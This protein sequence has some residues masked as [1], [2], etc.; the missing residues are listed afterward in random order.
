MEPN[1]LSF[2]CP[3]LDSFVA[4]SIFTMQHELTVHSTYCCKISPLGF[5]FVKKKTSFNKKKGQLL[6]HVIP[7]FLHMFI[8]DSSTLLKP[9]FSHREKSPG[10]EQSLLVCIYFYWILKEFVT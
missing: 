2:L 5:F 9:L 8:F 7:P 3:P 4:C 10:K 1:H 6:M